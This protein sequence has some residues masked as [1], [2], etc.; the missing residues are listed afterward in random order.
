MTYPNLFAKLLAR[1]W[2]ESD[3]E[4]LADGNLMRVWRAAEAIAKRLQRTA[5]QRDVLVLP[6]VVVC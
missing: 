5:R 6:G 4:R 1:G 3:L 2:S